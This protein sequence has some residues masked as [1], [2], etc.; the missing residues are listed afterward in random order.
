[1]S[2]TG[3]VPFGSG[4]MDL[5]DTRFAHMVKGTLNQKRNLILAV[6]AKKWELKD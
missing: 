2:A 5:D 3:D 6:V 1:M 4:Q